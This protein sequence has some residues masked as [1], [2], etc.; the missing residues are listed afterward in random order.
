MNS[1]RVVLLFYGLQLQPRVGVGWRTVGQG[2]FF[3]PLCDLDLPFSGLSRDALKFKLH[4]IP[5]LKRE[6]EDVGLKK[7]KGVV[8][9]WANRKAQ[10]YHAH[11]NLAYPTWP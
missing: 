2:L 8:A 5:Q 11:E 1:A 3:Q 10:S 4:M 7:E 9:S 6:H